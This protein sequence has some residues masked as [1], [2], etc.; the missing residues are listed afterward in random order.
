MTTPL[1]S[2]LPR[3]LSLKAAAKYLGCGVGPIREIIL[4]K[5]IIA[6]KLTGQGIRAPLY[7]DRL[8]LDAWVDK[9]KKA[10]D[11]DR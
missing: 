5:E 8:D 1:P 6:I 4:K 10:A 7:V 9:K 3:L 2:I 11:C